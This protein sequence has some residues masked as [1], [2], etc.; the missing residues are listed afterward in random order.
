MKTWFITGASR[1]LG[2]ATA[3]AA[4]ALGDQVVATGRDPHK[5]TRVLGDDG[6]VLAAMLDV[7]DPKS[8]ERAVGAAV[9]RF[10]RIDVLVNNAGYGLLGAFEELSASSIEKEFATNVFGAFAV[11]RAVLPVMRAQRAGHVISIASL[12]G[13]VGLD[14]VSI[15][16]STKFALAGWSESLSLELARFG[17]H[18]T[19]VYPGMFRT[20]FLD[21]S[22]AVHADLSIK[23]YTEAATAARQG[24]DTANHRQMGDPAIFGRVMIA[25]ANAAHPPVHFAV[26]SDSFD[27]MIDKAAALQSAAEKWRDLTMATD[28]K[29]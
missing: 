3:R 5:I 15:Y 19:V 7:T 13:L 18:A 1:G 22:S 10:K 14:M 28:I 29:S 20:D 8:I 25:M 27:A 24:R 2:L 12:C 23:D 4:L 6:H 9:D 26:G 16:C 11:T 17:I 21:G